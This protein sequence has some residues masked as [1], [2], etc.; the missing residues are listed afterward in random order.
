[1]L[2]EGLGRGAGLGQGGA[3]ALGPPGAPTPGSP[4]AHR[5][6]EALSDFQRTLAQLRDNTTSDYTQLGLRFKLQ[7]WEVSM[8]GA[9]QQEAVWLG[10]GGCLWAG[11]RGPSRAA[12]PA[13][14]ALPLCH[15]GRWARVK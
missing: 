12:D 1:M 4:T 3:L 5:F 15:R 10:P 8:W 2:Q 9:G 11:S 13:L 7:A 6:Q 14:W